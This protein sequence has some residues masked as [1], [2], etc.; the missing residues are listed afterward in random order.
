MMLRLRALGLFGVQTT[1]GS[2]GNRM[3]AA[4]AAASS[5]P[6]QITEVDHDQAAVASFLR[7]RPIALLYGV[8]PATAATLA[9]HG[10]HTIGA[11]SDTPLL[12]LQRLLGA[13]AGRDVRARA[14]GHDPR[15]VTPHSPSP[16]LSADRLFSQDELDPDQHRRALLSI[17]EQLGAQLRGRR[18]VCRTLTLTVRYADRTSTTKTRTLPE[19]TSHSTALA[20]AA[21]DLHATLGLQRARV[22]AT[23][24]RAHNLSPAEHAHHQLTLNPADDKARQIEAAADRARVRFGPAAITP[25]ALARTPRRS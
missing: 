18:E 20:R 14:H 21:Y 6:G 4:M 2:A 8:G 17:T 16:S 13:T 15:P 12:T 5:P 23:A 24:L 10:L 7:P 11:V 9:R 19:A 22:R 25:T 3:L 1:V